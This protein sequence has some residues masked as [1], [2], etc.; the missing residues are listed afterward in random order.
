MVG[1]WRLH[2]WLVHYEDNRPAATP[3]G[4][5]PSGLLIYNPDGFMS[6]TVGNRDRPSFPAGLSPRRLDQD[7]ISSAYWS[8]FHYSG[9]FRIESDCVVHSVLHSLNPNMV[10]TEQV[11]QMKLEEPVL[12]LSAA[13]SVGAVNR[14]H[15]LIWHRIKVSRFPDRASGGRRLHSPGSN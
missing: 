1:A 2:S 12:T 6:A 3:Y 14:L 4:A 7:L 5:E 10:G 11:R 15:E 9:S 8:F 13:E